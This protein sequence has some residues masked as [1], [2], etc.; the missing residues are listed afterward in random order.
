MNMKLN[1]DILA[2]MRNTYANRHEPESLR[3]FVDIYWRT[4][5]AIAFLIVVLVVAYGIWNLSRILGDLGRA[6][7]ITTPPTPVLSRAV[8]NATMQAFDTR[9]TR[10]DS[11]KVNPPAAVPDP[12][13]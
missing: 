11:F 2:R 7:E 1:I 4:V 3:T 5:L 12:S 13:K 10:F 9:Q 8:L 6:P